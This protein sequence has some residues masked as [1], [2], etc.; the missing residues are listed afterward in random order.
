[1]YKKILICEETI[2]SRTILTELLQSMG[3]YIVVEAETA[4]EAIHMYQQHIKKGSPFDLVIV[5]AEMKKSGGM[6][7][8]SSLAGLPPTSTFV[9]SGT[10]LS[11]EVLVE[12]LKA[13]VKHFLT[14]PYR[15]RQ[16]EEILGQLL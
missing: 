5:D 1:M 16:V 13:G 11:D 15:K 2:Y 3:E 6:R 14:K 7:I 8:I 4:D 10:R 12:Y 9:L